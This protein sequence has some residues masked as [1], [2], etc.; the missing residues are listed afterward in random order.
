MSRANGGVVPFFVVKQRLKRVYDL[1]QQLASL[2]AEK[3]DYH[4]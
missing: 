1:A 2:E 3:E 4:A